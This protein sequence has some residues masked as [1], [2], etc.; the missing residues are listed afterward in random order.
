MTQYTQ[1]EW[2]AY[3]DSL[4]GLLKA[5]NEALI[6]KERFIAELQRTINKQAQNLDKA[7]GWYKY[8]QDRPDMVFKGAGILV[9]MGKNDLKEQ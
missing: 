6:T 7:D 8:F 1:E 4:I 3:K 5:A 2:I 9:I